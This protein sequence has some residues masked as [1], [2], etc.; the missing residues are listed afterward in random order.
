MD[1]MILPEDFRD[2]LKLL[3]K[4]RVEYLLI[5]GYA[6]FY[7]GYPRATEDIDFWVAISPDNAQKLVQVM[8]DFG[9][10]NVTP[11]LFL[12]EHQLTRIGFKPYRVEVLTT[13]SGVQFETCYARRVVDTIDGIEVNI[14]SLEDLKQNKKASGRLKDQD[15]V[16]NLP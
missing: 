15:D 6:V 16:Q 8:Q 14:I 13:I 9:L 2:F 5:G 12:Q 7:H 11:E 1:E 3:N 4:H 10:S